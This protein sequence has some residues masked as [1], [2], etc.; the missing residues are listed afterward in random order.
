MPTT[1]YY[2]LRIKKLTSLTH[3]KFFLLINLI[4]LLALIIL[5]KHI[6]YNPSRSE[7]IGYYL[8][9]PNINSYRIGDRVLICLDNKSVMT[10]LHKLGLPYQSGVCNYDAPFL[11]KTIVAAAM[12]HV[13]INNSGIYV[14]SRLMTHNVGYKTYKDTKLNPILALDVRLGKGEYFLLGSTPTSFDSRYFGV[15]KQNQ[16]HYKAKLLIGVSPR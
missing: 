13:E 1:N 4:I 16:I 3:Y 8:T 12:D 9:Y 5:D 10:I 14:N 15:I 2:K 6:Y 7:P 11:L